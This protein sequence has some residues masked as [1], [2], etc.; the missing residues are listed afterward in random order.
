MKWNTL[1]FLQYCYE[2]LGDF[3]FQINSEKAWMWNIAKS[4]MIFLFLFFIFFLKNISVI[5]GHHFHFQSQSCK[6]GGHF[7]EEAG[8]RKREISCQMESL[9]HLPV[10]DLGWKNDMFFILL[11]S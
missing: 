4:V 7:E 1:G 10:T 6:L 2:R 8:T 11:W 5:Q 9:H 3:F